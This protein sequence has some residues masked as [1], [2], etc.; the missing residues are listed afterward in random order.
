MNLYPAAC[1]V[2]AGRPVGAL[3]TFQGSA[4]M[5]MVRSADKNGNAMNLYPGTCPVDRGRPYSG[6]GGDGG[7]AE[8][9]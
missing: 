7:L 2:A 8:R 9:A 4:V 5:L 3:F 1:A 6:D